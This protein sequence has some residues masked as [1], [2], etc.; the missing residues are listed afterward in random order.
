MCEICERREL[1][2]SLNSADPCTIC[3]GEGEG[4]SLDG[5]FIEPCEAC[6]GS[7]NG[8]VQRFI[9][10]TDKLNLHIPVEWTPGDMH[11]HA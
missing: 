2:S 6:L 9:C 3:E 1:R 10:A 5:P 4:P 8:V 7:G 11:F